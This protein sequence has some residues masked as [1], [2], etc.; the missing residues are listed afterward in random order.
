MYLQI[1]HEV[2]MIRGSA[3]PS[4]KTWHNNWNSLTAK[5]IDIGTCQK[6]IHNACEIIE[7]HLAKSEATNMTLKVLLLHEDDYSDG[8][9]YSL[10]GH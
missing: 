2:D 10:L 3:K 9:N 7:L 1:A 4:P 8:M 6:N 5:V